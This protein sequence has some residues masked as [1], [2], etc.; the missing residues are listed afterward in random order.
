MVMFRW[1]WLLFLGRD[2]LGLEDRERLLQRLWMV[3]DLSE[4]VMD[5][6]ELSLML[7]AGLALFV[8]LEYASILMV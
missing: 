8:R 7:V 1:G 6:F 4:R 5:R 2:G 3:F